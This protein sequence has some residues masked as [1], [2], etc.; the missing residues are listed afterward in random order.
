MKKGKISLPTGCPL[1]LITS[2]YLNQRIIWVGTTYHLACGDAILSDKDV[3]SDANP[4][5]Y[6]CLTTSLWKML[7]AGIN[8]GT[9]WRKWLRWICILP[10]LL[11]SPESSISD[12]LWWIACLAEVIQESH[13][14]E[15]ETGN[16]ITLVHYR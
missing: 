5:R 1:K 4:L 12:V 6:Y 2:S 3:Y 7:A 8:C 13:G 10:E 11:P 15:R 16:P 9:L 14:G